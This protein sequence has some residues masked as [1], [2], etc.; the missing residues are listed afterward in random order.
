L[1]IGDNDNADV[2]QQLYGLKKVEGVAEN[3]AVE[4]EGEVAVRLERVLIGI[5]AEENSPQQP[6]RAS[7]K[8]SV[9]NG[10]TDRRIEILLGSHKTE[11]SVQG[12]SRSPSKG[13]N[14]EAT[15]DLATRKRQSRAEEV[16]TVHRMD[17]EYPL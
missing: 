8:V 11:D 6:A 12:N 16:L 1:A 13:T 4:T 5:Q 7:L 17:Q 14:R 15:D 2:A 3:A 10:K 9:Q